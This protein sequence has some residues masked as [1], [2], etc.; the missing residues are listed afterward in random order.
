MKKK[1]VKPQAIEVSVAVEC[2]ADFATSN[3]VK[4]SQPSDK[5]SW[6]KASD[7]EYDNWSNTQNAPLEGETY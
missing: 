4:A 2:L 7:D 3:G 5:S 1:Y 6:N